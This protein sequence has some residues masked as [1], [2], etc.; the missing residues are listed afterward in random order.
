MAR[1]Q[2]FVHKF[3]P[4][5]D[6]WLRQ[7]A[8]DVLEPALPIV[9][10]HHHLW[11]RPGWRYLLHDLLSD[12]ST[13]HDVRATVF[14]DCHTM[15]REDGDPAFAP[16]GETEFANGIAAMSASGQYGAIRACAGI[17]SNVDL[18]LGERARDVLEAQVAAGNGRFRGIRSL[19]NWHA[20]PAIKGTTVPA[21]PPG[22]LADATYRRGVA[23]LRPL[24]LSLELWMFHTQLGELTDL[25]RA[26]PDTRLMID[27]CGGPIGVGPY[28]DRRQETFGEWRQAMRALAGCENVAVKIGGL[29]MPLVGFAL[30][31]RDRPPGS[32][33]LAELWRPYVETCIEAFGTKRAMF[34]SNF[35][36]D[37]IGAGYAVL[38]NAFKRLAAGCSADEKAD[39][40]HRSATTFY[41][42][43]PAA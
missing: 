23:Q 1:Q 25:A 37:K 34:E 28:A 33:E 26:F 30:H 42:L 38:W 9:D 17:V 35:P 22:T 16:V 24:D 29:A 8:E 7:T 14:V 4:V 20:D 43:P 27:H 10:P 15:Y 5:R 6:D 11:D 31:E 19:A 3:P 40:F 39:L 41:R 21:L 2:T 13:G 12:T 18:R 32:A 36:V